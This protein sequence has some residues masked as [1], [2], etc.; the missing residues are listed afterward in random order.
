M[1]SFVNGSQYTRK[2]NSNCTLMSE[3][4]F[5]CDRSI[6]WTAASI[7]QK[8][9]LPISALLNNSFDEKT[10]KVSKLH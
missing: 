4:H 2:N 10:C 9:V 6:H 8:A 1:A 7:D 3:V 5:L